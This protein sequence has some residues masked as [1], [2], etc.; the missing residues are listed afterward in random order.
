[1]DVSGGSG[2]GVFGIL[3]G[4]NGRIV[5]II[6]IGF[7]HGSDRPPAI[8]LWIGTV[9]T[10]TTLAG[11]DPAGETATDAAASGDGDAR[12]QWLAETNAR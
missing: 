3:Q 9:E 11:V 1:M 12:E 8:R 5:R 10:A 4:A 7:D 2:P 6:F